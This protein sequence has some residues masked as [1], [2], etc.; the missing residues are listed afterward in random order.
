MLLTTAQFTQE[1]IRDITQVSPGDV[2]QWRKA[3]AYLAAKPGKAARFAFS[4]L[5]GLA[6]TRELTG[7]LGARI[8]EIGAGVDTLFRVLAEARPAHLEGLVA[9]VERADARLIPTS[10]L[11]ARQL[12]SPVFVA[13][14]DP[15]LAEI[16]ARMMPVAPGAS[17]AALPFPPQ[18]VRSGA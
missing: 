5:I 9:I 14:C 3:V 15:I 16:G 18:A 17:Q 2:R 12:R 10:D 6:L 1:Q 8:S 7:T 4:D 13:P 11:I